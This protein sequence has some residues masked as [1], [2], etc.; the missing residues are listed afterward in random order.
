[1]PAPPVS[2]TWVEKE[3]Y[4]GFPE[5]YQVGRDVFRPAWHIC[6]EQTRA[7]CSR[8]P[9]SFRHLQYPILFPACLA[10]AY[11]KGSI[12][13]SWQTQI[14]ASGPDLKLQ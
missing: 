3:K 12:L 14:Q 5:R 4:T 1:M 13:R 10:G 7:L 6:L 8:Y 11:L 9:N 2:P